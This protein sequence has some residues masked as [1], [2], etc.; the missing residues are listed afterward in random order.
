[1]DYR[2]AATLLIALGAAFMGYIYHIRTRHFDPSDRDRISSWPVYKYID[3]YLKIST[4]TITEL[5]IYSSHGALLELHDNTWLLFAGLMVAGLA[6][7]LFA[8]AMWTLDTQY[9]PAH[10]SH[11]PN[12]IITTGPYRFIRH[13][14]YTSNLLLLGSMFLASGSLWI[15]LNLGILIAYYLPTIAR[16]E[17]AMKQRFPEYRQYVQRTGRFFPRFRFPAQV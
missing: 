1:M 13:P 3:W 15:T 2:L 5:A 6:L 14:V 4:V 16:E 9:T 10:A 11:L 8:L 17:Q 12:Q 7:A